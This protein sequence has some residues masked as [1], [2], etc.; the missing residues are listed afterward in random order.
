MYYSRTEPPE[1]IYKRIRQKKQRMKA[2]G[3][4]PNKRIDS[5]NILLSS[6]YWRVTWQNSL[7]V[8]H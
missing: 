4:Q 5:S 3:T 6:E 7:T 8:L 1:N 2:K